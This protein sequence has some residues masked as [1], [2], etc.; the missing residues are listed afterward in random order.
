MEAV[1]DI[2]DELIG[3]WQGVTSIMSISKIHNQE[4]AC[5]YCYLSRQRAYQRQELWN[6][7]PAWRLASWRGRV[8]RF[9]LRQRAK[10]GLI[11]HHELFFPAFKCTT[12]FLLII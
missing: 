6:K 5:S 1:S 12:K 7:S 3:M 10:L 8:I 11:L 9:H 4:R 2:R